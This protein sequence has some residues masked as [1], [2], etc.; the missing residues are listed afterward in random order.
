MC[1]K[2]NGKIYLFYRQHS[3]LMQIIRISIKY[4][5]YRAQEIS[6][7]VHKIKNIFQFIK[8][9][10]NLL[11]LKTKI[12]IIRMKN[13]IIMAIKQM[14]RVRPEY[15]FSFIPFLF[16]SAFSN[17]FISFMFIFFYSLFRFV[18][19][20]IF[21]HAFGSL[22]MLVFPCICKETSFCFCQFI[23]TITHFLHTNCDELSFFFFFFLF[24]FRL[25]RN[26]YPLCH[27]RCVTIR[28]GFTFCLYFVHKWK[29][30]TS[31]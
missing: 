18:D 30:I 27:C 4:Y 9:I 5:S 29:E 13:V 21:F 2:M 3:W 19:K 15:F 23:S 8:L 12:I 17:L 31:N 20:T 25:F 1:V 22:I 6:R 11:R 26:T 14:D 28:C 7:P 24:C 16:F 10:F